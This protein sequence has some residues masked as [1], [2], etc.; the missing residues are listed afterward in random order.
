MIKKYKVIKSF[1]CLHWQI[2]NVWQILD[3]K[4]INS[5]FLYTI[6]YLLDKWFL[7]ELIL[8]NK[9]PKYKIWDYVVYNFIS[10]NFSKITDICIND[11]WEFLY[12]NFCEVQL[13]LPTPEELQLYYR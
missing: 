3:E 6:W 10:T 7:Q 12:N 13:R 8:D 2:A 5:H 4:Y 11:S 9:K 1:Y